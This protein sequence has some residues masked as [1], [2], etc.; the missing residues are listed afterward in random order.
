[1]GEFFARSEGLRPNTVY[2]YRAYARNAEGTAYG[3]RASF[4]TKPTTF[5]WADA[6]ENADAPGWWRSEWFGTFHG[7]D[8]GWIYHS[9]LGWLYVSPSRW[10]EGFWFWQKQLGWV[11]TDRERFQPGS[12]YLFLANENSWCFRLEKIPGDGTNPAKIYFFRY[13]DNEWFSIDL[14]HAIGGNQ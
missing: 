4:T 10:D 3:L 9:E 7:T 11:W 8:F 5:D 2:H 6:Q 1:M 14:D 13:S 12:R